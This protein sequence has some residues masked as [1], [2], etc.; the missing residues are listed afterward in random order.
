MKVHH[1]AASWPHKSRQKTSSVGWCSLAYGGDQSQKTFASTDESGFFASRMSE[2]KTHH[3]VESVLT[4]SDG[5]KSECKP[6][7]DLS[8][9]HVPI[10]NMTTDDTWIGSFKFNNLS[11]LLL[12]AE[13]IED[14]NVVKDVIMKF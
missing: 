9:E 3:A 11:S 6:P 8:S 14:I 1:A 5:M 7:P 10:S 12:K 13:K 2:E 4:I